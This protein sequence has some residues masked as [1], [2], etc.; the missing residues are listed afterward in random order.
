MMT[1]DWRWN[2]INP[3]TNRTY[4]L[5]D[6]RMNSKYKGYT[7]GLKSLA[8][9]PSLLAFCIFG[10]LLWLFGKEENGDEVLLRKYRCDTRR[11]RQL[12]RL[13]R[14]RRRA[15]RQ[16]QKVTQN[17]NSRHTEVSQITNT[18]TCK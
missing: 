9:V 17:I 11:E 12:R 15:E 7:L 6:H 10:Y 8:F 2:H 1:Y 18:Y 14:K 16:K 5:E 13:K 4:G 3:K